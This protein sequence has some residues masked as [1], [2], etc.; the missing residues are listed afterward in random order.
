MTPENEW[1]TPPER[2]YFGGSLDDEDD[3]LYE[4]VPDYVTPAEQHSPFEPTAAD[5]LAEIRGRRG[6][7]N[8]ASRRVEHLR[9]VGMVGGEDDE[10]EDDGLWDMPA[11]RSST[12]HDPLPTLDEVAQ[13][14]GSDTSGF[15]S[16]YEEDEQPRRRFFRGARRRADDDDHAQESVLHGLDEAPDVPDEPEPD[17]QPQDQSAFDYPDEDEDTGLRAVALV[18]DD[19]DEDEQI[20]PWDDQPQWSGQGDDDWADDVEDEDEDE[21]DGPSLSEISARGEARRKRAKVAKVVAAGVGIAAVSAGLVVLPDVIGQATP[22][23]TTSVQDSADWFSDV[24]RITEVTRGLGMLDST[25]VWRIDGGEK[26]RT[27]VFSAGIMRLDGQRMTIVDPDDGKTPMVSV[28]VTEPIEYTLE[29]RDRNGDPVISWVSG[30]KLFS[31]LRGEEKPRSW[32]LPAGGRVKS[33][34]GGLMITADDGDYAAFPEEKSLARI[35]APAGYVVAAVD[36]RRAVTVNPANT[37]MAIVPIE[38]GRAENI[39][40][41]PPFDGARIHSTV[42][43][44]DGVAVVLWS[45]NAMPR[46]LTLSVHS[47]QDGSVSSSVPVLAD[48]A[49]SSTWN[50]GQGGVMGYYGPYTFDMKTKKPVSRFSEQESV[51]GAAG[52]ITWIRSGEDYVYQVDG[53]A[54]SDARKIAGVTGDGL[55]VVREEDGSLTA[56]ERQG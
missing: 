38:G 28:K 49:S 56:H 5:R 36:G 9:A 22:A 2:N 42:H 41:A 10:E 40:L 3:D 37:K 17:P 54:S 45:S 24:P 43:A 4:E 18:E 35:E 51:Q 30:G 46:I 52:P 1:R 20:A 31:W 55:I 50:T 44:G 47:L 16:A 32:E 13:P 6:S 26:V 8:G 34:G 53:K 23:G 15:V 25:P 29:S 11:P 39:T 48:K 7:G 19:E 21:D 14:G 12:A 27:A 33:P